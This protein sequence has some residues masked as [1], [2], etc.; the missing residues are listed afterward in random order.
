MAKRKTVEPPEIRLP[1]GPEVEPPAEPA[2]TKT[3]ERTVRI[4]V[5]IAD[6]PQTGYRSRRFHVEVHL[7]HKEAI[8][9]RGIQAAL[10]ARHARLA[11]GRV[12]QSK[13]D[14]VRWMFEQIAGG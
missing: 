5:P 6:T 3:A 12:V 11:G 8:A 13:A 4:D 1:N 10:D 9:F 7:G 2:V 14:V